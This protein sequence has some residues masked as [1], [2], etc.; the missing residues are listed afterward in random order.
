MSDDANMIIARDKRIKSEGNINYA[1]NNRMKNEIES[2]KE[3]DESEFKD[4]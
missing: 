3:I 2:I 1:H 4:S